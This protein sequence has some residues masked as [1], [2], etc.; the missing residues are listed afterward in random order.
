MVGLIL[1]VIL[2][3]IVIIILLIG[4]HTRTG[5]QQRLLETLYEKINKLSSDV[6]WLS[7]GI[8]PGK[9]Y[10][11]SSVK[12]EQEPEPPIAPEIILT[13]YIPLHEQLGSKSEELI[14]PEPEEIG[15]KVE[16][17]VFI[18]KE[19]PV[20]EENENWYPQ[21]RD[22]EKF[23]GE[24]LISKIG[25][26][27]L[28]LGIAFFVKYAIDKNWVNE[29][30]RVIIGL[31]S[32]G[33]LIG[34]AHYFRNTYRS[35][36]SVLVGG[37]LTVFYFSIAFA[38]HQYHLIGQTAAFIIMVIISALGVVLS[39]F[40]N[41]QELAI[42][43][44]IGGFIT[45]F[46]VSTGQD[47]YVALFTYLCILN[48]GLMVLAWFKRWP[49]INIIALFFTTIIYGG[50]VIKRT[51]FEE[52]GTLPY[53]DALLFATLFYALFMVMNV[54]NMLRLNKKFGAFEFIVLLSTNFLYYAAG[55]I[56]LQYW[57]NGAY[58]GLFTL[59]L[60]IVNL[61]LAAGFWRNKKVDRNFIFLLIGLAIT[62]IS[63]SIPIELKGNNIVLAWAG[64]T[65]VL[66]W[67]YQRTKLD[68]LRS[69]ALIVTALTLGSLVITWSDIYLSNYSTIPIIANKGFITSAVV[70]IMLFLMYRLGRN[71]NSWIRNTMLSLAIVVT[72]LCG[73]LEIWYQFATRYQDA[74]LQVVYL[75]VYTFSVSILILYLFRK[76]SVFPS[77]KLLLTIGCFS[78]YLFGIASTHE[79]SLSLFNASRFELFLGHWVA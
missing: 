60:G 9:E 10:T 67:L 75:Q 41:R 24:N 44:T 61:L 54:I 35:F 2:V 65:V 59:L 32:G 21:N 48:S 16:A 6:E 66:Y 15:E 68:L 34:F 7:Q 73:G 39:L 45:P 38:F 23:I 27:V 58:K 76:T 30:G 5:E 77:L 55:T 12:K 52:P 42:L 46:L 26:T 1:L 57:D 72:Y 63:L 71:E 37:G 74:P 8:Q 69:T 20:Q 64:E 79:V 13:D 50:W 47:N 78:Y 4:I 70:A 43:A 33:I 11:A 25:I 28:V 19:Q 22:W 18:R 14:Q 17:P 49:A 51:A 56:T 53:K 31:V 40:Y 3:P 36:S 29:A 62:F